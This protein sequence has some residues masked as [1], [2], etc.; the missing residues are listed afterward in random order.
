MIAMCL[1]KVV[2]LIFQPFN[3]PFLGFVGGVD[4]LVAVLLGF[5]S[6]VVDNV[7]LVA[8]AQG[9]YDLD[10]HPVDGTLKEHVWNPMFGEKTFWDLLDWAT[11]WKMWV[12]EGMIFDSSFWECWDAGCI[13]VVQ[14]L[15][16]IF[17]AIGMLVEYVQPGCRVRTFC[18]LEGFPGSL[19][20]EIICDCTSAALSP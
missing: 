14:H 13:N 10:A 20:T 5:A 1:H 7:P 6:A 2:K 18:Q 16:L 19:Q 3:A 11:F 15:L 17:I 4:A 9:M 8:A 12:L